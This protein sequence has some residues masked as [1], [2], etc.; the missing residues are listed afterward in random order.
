MVEGLWEF[1]ATRTGRPEQGQRRGDVST[2][3]HRAAHVTKTV[4]DIS[5]ERADGSE[6]TIT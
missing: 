3:V 2:K 6:A 5:D 4:T 1:E